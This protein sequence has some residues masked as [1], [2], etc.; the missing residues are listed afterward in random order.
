MSEEGD[1]PP[2]HLNRHPHYLG[3][4]YRDGIKPFPVTEFDPSFMTCVKNFGQYEYGLI[5]VTTLV[6]GYIGYSGMS[7]LV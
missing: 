1:V 5:A 4:R 2:S 3:F 6:P 7:T